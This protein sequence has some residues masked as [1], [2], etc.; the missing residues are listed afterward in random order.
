MKVVYLETSAFLTW[1]FDEPDASEVM[2]TVN[3]AELIVTSSLIEVETLRACNRALREKLIDSHQHKVITESFKSQKKGWFVMNIDEEV[4]LRA[5]R[6]FPIEPLRSL[7]A[8][9]LAT[10]LEYRKLYPHCRVLSLDKRIRENA[11]ALGM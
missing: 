3:T 2:S 5:S 7:D 9:H 6:D 11:A 8:L 10:A 4:V 1:L